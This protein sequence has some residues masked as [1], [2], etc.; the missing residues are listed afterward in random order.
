[1]T[2]SRPT[3]S[4]ARAAVGLAVVIAVLS[5]AAC[6]GPAAS[7]AP[8]VPGSSS[9]SAPTSTVSPSATPAPSTSSSSSPPP[10][11]A[12]AGAKVTVTIKDF[13]FGVPASVAPGAKVTLTNAD[14]EAHTVTSKDG[15]FDVKVAGRGGTATLTAPGKPG[16]YGLTCDFHA[17]M[18]GV[19]VVS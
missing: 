10:A 7:T 12:A 9:A 5:I 4:S 16:R 6:G 11:T 19:L 15:G 17:D 1:M 13:M 14:T 8:G 3:R 18:S 2:T